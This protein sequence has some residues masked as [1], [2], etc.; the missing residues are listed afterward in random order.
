MVVKSMLHL[1]FVYEQQDFIMLCI[2]KIIAN[3]LFDIEYNNRFAILQ[4]IY[5]IYCISITISYLVKVL[6][7]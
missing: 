6:L 7:I 2:L 3:I 5:G 4:L 1:E